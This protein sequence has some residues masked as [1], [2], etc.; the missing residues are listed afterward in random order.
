MLPIAF[1]KQVPLLWRTIVELGCVCAVNPKVARRRGGSRAAFSVPD[2]DF[3]STSD[4]AYL[5]S[6]SMQR[7]YL[8]HNQVRAVRCRVCA[9]LIFCV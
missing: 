4:C 9:A 3:K 2:F 1:H 5:E 8:H 7:I 6:G